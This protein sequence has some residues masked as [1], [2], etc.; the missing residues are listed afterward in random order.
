MT[1]TL[2]F[3]STGLFWLFVLGIWEAGGAARSDAPAAVQVPAYTLADVGQHATE[4]DCWMA[5]HGKV[6]DLTLYLPEH[7]TRPSVILPW[8]GKESTEAYNTKM[9]GR[10][11]SPGADQLLEAH[12]IG[13]LRE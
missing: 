12:L 1:R 8:C 11:H 7:P 9:R 13:R 5:I 3:A 10:P 6:Y 4:A 2:F